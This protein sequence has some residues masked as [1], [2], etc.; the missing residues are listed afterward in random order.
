MKL[1]YLVAI[2]SVACGGSKSGGDDWS[3]R[4]LKSTTDSVKGVAFSIDLPEGLVKDATHAKDDVTQL[5]EGRKGE[6]HDFSAPSVMVSYNSIPAKSLDEF[7]KDAMPSAKDDVVRKDKLADGYIVTL[8]GQS[9]GIVTVLVAKQAG[10][11][12]LGSRCS[13]ANDDGLPNLDAT[14][15][16]LEKICLSLAIKK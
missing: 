1:A 13:Q 6:R 16:W 11:V 9:K 3:T 14:R 8:Q 4:P 5:W 10:E 2:V 7:V 15:A 12:V